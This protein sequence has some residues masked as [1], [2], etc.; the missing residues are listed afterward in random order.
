MWASTRGYCSAD[1]RWGKVKSRRPHIFVL[2]AE[3]R[4]AKMKGIKYNDGMTDNGGDCGG[5]MEL[6]QE[7]D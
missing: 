5:H 1:H 6:L 2:Q 3:N 4:K 7:A